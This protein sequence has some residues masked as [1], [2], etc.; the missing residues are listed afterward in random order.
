MFLEI[1]MKM[2][3]QLII[4]V[5]SILG[6][7]SVSSQ[8]VWDCNAKL[9]KEIVDPL[10][11]IYTAAVDGLPYILKGLD[12]ENDHLTQL[13]PPG[14]ADTVEQVLK[15]KASE[16]CDLAIDDDQNLQFVCVTANSTVD[17]DLGLCTCAGIWQKNV[18][19]ALDPIT[20]TVKCFAVPGSK[21]RKITSLIRHFSGWLDCFPGAECQEDPLER[22]LLIGDVDYDFAYGYCSC[23]DPTAKNC[24][25]LQ[26]HYAPT[27]AGVPLT[28]ARLELI[29]TLVL[30]IYIS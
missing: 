14:S 7:S 13:Y 6:L 16:L 28:L 21:C 1:E 3:S 8:G 26:D 24:Q 25:Q 2:K 19:S 15:A 5:L 20:N 30:S 4:V 27:R 23:T 18:I 11:E 22:R 10:L 9:W 17:P 12:R 29:M